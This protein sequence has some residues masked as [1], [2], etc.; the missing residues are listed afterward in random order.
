MQLQNLHKKNLSGCLIPLSQSEDSFS[1]PP[2]PPLRG[3]TTRLNFCT[4]QKLILP[5]EVGGCF[6][7]ANPAA[8]S[9]HPGP[10]PQGGREGEIR[11]GR[12]LAIGHRIGSLVSDV[13]GLSPGTRHLR[14]CWCGDARLKAENGGP[15]SRRSLVDQTRS[16]PDDAGGG[17]GRLA[18]HGTAG[19]MLVGGQPPST[20]HGTRRLCPCFQCQLAGLQLCRCGLRRTHD[21]CGAATNGGMSVGDD[22]LDDQGGLDNQSDEQQRWLVAAHHHVPVQ[23]FGKFRPISR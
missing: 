12:A 2:P 13:E 17:G 15:I 18:C 23:A 4:L 10:P 19:G 5:R 9:P 22:G 7:S 6:F 16:C 11:E 20:R 8:R 21:G 3:R 14:R 1:A